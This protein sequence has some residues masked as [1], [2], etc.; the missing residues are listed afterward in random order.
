METTSAATSFRVWEIL[1]PYNFSAVGIG[2]MNLPPFVGA[3]FGFFYG[4]WLNDKSIIALSKRNQ[5]IYEPEMCLW[6]AMPCAIIVPAGILIFGIGL[7][8]VSCHQGC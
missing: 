6:L 4:G 2:L 1:T 8:N 3:L 5:G 7:A